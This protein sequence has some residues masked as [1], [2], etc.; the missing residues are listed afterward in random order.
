MNHHFHICE[1]IFPNINGEICTIV[2]CQKGKLRQG[3]LSSF[4]RHKKF[5]VQTHSWELEYML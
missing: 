2:I 1:L 5:S 4:S 3:S